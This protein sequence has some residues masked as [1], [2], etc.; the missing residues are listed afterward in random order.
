MTDRVSSIKAEI[1]MLRKEVK[2]NIAEL[3]NSESERIGLFKD[4]E[5]YD[6]ILSFIDSMQEEPVSKEPK[7][8][9]GDILYNVSDGNKI[10]IIDIVADQYK[11]ECGDEYPHYEFF[12]YI[13]SNYSKYPISEDLD[14][15]A[16][17]ILS[18]EDSNEDWDRLVIRR[19][20]KHFTDW[21]KE[22]LLAK[23][24][25]VTIA[26][27]YPNGYG[28][29]SQIVDTNESLPFGDKLKVLV[30]KED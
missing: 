24:V 19:T 1:K 30:I 21:Q 17:E 13:E 15:Y 8:K 9:Q 18:F 25:D 22:Q 4:L 2:D 14:D 12:G 16:K 3:G 11:F 20:A 7:F 29:Y 6:N 5:I 28:G 27:P 23:A 26:I 10:E